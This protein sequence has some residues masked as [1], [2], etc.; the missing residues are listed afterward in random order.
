MFFFSFFFLFIFFFPA[1]LWLGLNRQVYSV[2]FVPI[3]SLPILCLSFDCPSA[4][5]LFPLMLEEEI[6]ISHERAY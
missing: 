3:T 6:L 1:A 2:Q 4:H 5:L